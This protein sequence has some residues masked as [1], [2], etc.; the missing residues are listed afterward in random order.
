MPNGCSQYSMEQEEQMDREQQGDS[1][2]Q[3]VNFAT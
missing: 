2:L 1:Y 3:K